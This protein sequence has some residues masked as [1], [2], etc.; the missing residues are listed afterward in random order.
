MAESTGTTTDKGVGLAIMLGAVAV[1]G[2][3]GMATLAPEPDAG[4]AFGVAMAFGAFAV[5]AIHVY[6]D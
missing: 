3:L 5:V 1:I 4:L 6:W 2:A